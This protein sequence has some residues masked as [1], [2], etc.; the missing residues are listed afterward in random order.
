MCD[1]TT[2]E[3]DKHGRQDDP[4]YLKWSKALPDTT[5]KKSGA[6]RPVGRECDHCS[7]TRWVNF[8]GIAQME[9][10]EQR[11]SNRAVE[12]KFETIRGQR[13]RGESKYHVSEKVDIEELVTS[14]QKKPTAKSTRRALGRSYG[15]SLLPVTSINFDNRRTKKP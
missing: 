9:L 12:E 15:L 1:Q 13:A 2:H 5:S 11:S 6:R 3:L 7:N 14:T 8:N 10:I 4:Q